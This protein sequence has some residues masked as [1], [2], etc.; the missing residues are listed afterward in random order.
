MERARISFF[1]LLSIPFRE[2]SRTETHPAACF[3]LFFHAFTAYMLHIAHKIAFCAM[4]EH[5][6]V[7]VFQCVHAKI[8][9]C[10]CSIFFWL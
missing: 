2:R 6:S 1:W 10:F 9:P 4:P 7:C 3:S 8:A 5:T